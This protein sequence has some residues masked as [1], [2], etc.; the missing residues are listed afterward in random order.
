LIAG[1]SSSKPSWNLSTDWHAKLH[2]ELPAVRDL[3][4]TPKDGFSPKDEQEVADYVTRHLGE[5]LH[6]RGIIV[7]RE[8]QI[9]RG[10]GVGTG[11]RTDIHV[12]AVMAAEPEGNVGRTYAI[13]E[14]KGNWNGELSSAME[15][16]LRDRYLNE[17]RCKDGVY[18]IAWFAC[19]KWSETDSR[20]TKCPQVPLSE[21][22]ESFSK[23]PSELSRDGYS[24]AVM[25]LT[26]RFPERGRARSGES[27]DR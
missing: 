24:F 13:V 1:V 6:R 26:H 2:G 14:V 22:R 15:T 16:Q 7:N 17:N 11:Q 9:R 21:A 3:W 19:P 27:A 18:L 20:R 25:F 10:T 8:A 4:N 12:D 5:D 23:Q